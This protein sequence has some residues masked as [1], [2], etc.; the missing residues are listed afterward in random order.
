MS[1]NPFH[2]MTAVDAEVEL[3]SKYFY[4][5]RTY[6]YQKSGKLKAFSFRGQQ[7]FLPHKLVEVYIN[8]LKSKI[9]STVPELKDAN[10]FYDDSAKRM[11]VDGI[12]G[13]Y[14]EAKTELENEEDLMTKLTA[15]KE[16]LMS[17]PAPKPIEEPTETEPGLTI[18]DKV[19]TTEVNQQLPPGVFPTDIQIVRVQ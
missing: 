3:G 4:R 16:W 10:V 5:Q 8:E 9:L 14:V 17:K 19:V 1:Q 6:R 12:D 15:V 2:L 7:C 13:K 18:V 11:V